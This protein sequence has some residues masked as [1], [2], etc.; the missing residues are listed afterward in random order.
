MRASTVPCVRLRR[1]RSI[2]Q[3]PKVSS[4]EISE[5]SIETSGLLPASFLASATSFSSTGGNGAVHVPAA[6]SPSPLSCELRSKV[7]PALT[8]DAPGPMDTCRSNE[9]VPPQPYHLVE[10][11]HTRDSRSYPATPWFRNRLTFK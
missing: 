10:S 8:R 3:A 5:T 1:K 2:S 9:K 11:R 4:L 6:R 7:G